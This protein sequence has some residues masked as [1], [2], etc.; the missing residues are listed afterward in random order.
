[1][2]L[3]LVD[4][5]QFGPTDPLSDSSPLK[6]SKILS[7]LSSFTNGETC[8]K[9]IVRLLARKLCEARRVEQEDEHDAGDNERER[10]RDDDERDEAIDETKLL[11]TVKRKKHIIINA[12]T[13]H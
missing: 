12:R 10:E 3:F 11:A 5:S 9:Q 7:K 1:M 4:I 2:E 6:G 13:Q 8:T